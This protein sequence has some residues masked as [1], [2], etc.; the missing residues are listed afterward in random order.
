MAFGRMVNYDK[1]STYFSHNISIIEKGVLCSSLGVS[2]QHS[3]A[4]YL[5]LP[6]FIDCNKYDVFRFV[7]HKVWKRI[8]SWHSSY[9]SWASK[10]VL[11]K[12]IAQTILSYI[13]SV[14][15][16]PKNL[17]SKLECVMNKF[18]CCKYKSSRGVIRWLR[19]GDLCT[20][21]NAVVLAF[22]EFISLI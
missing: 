15:L 5:G 7:L 4:T 18:W 13:M 22:E 14:F 12:S 10:K 21:K 16:L 2:L 6:S 1:S 11:V 19:W 8:Q 20:H 17:C 9:L 3:S